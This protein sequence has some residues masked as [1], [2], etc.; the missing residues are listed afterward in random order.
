M[1]NEYFSNG[2]VPL[3]AKDVEIV[4]DK[5]EWELISWGNQSVKVKERVIEG[6]SSFK[7]YRKSTKWS[8]LLSLIFWFSIL[9]IIEKI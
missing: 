6:L 2:H 3:D 1:D 8:F 9:G 4:E 7:Y 5:V